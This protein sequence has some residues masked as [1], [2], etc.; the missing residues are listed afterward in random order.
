M[1]AMDVAHVW[2]FLSFLAVLRCNV[3]GGSVRATLRQN[4]WIEQGTTMEFP[5]EISGEGEWLISPCHVLVWAVH[6][7]QILGISQGM[8]RGVPYAI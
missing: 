2:K 1:E 4:W 8:S 7:I 5:G 3:I 6:P